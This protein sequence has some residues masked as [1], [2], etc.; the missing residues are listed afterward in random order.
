[1]WNSSQELLWQLQ[2]Q[3]QHRFVMSPSFSSLGA[4][5]LF[6]V[7][8]RQRET[9]LHPGILSA[10]KSEIM[11]LGRLADPWVTEVVVPYLSISKAAGVFKN[12]PRRYLL[13]TYS[14]L[15]HSAES[16]WWCVSLNMNHV[17]LWRCPPNPCETCGLASLPPVTNRRQ[18]WERKMV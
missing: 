4:S 3:L 12:H 7:Y 2:W 14:F 15:V 13:K 1:M 17:R 9:S 10:E 6:Q 8:I 18:N 5:K 11:K 16:I